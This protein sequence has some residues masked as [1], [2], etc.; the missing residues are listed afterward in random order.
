MTAALGIR[1]LALAIVVAAVAPATAAA[2]PRTLIVRADGRDV[3]AQRLS[4]CLPNHHEAARTCEEETANGPPL[5]KVRAGARARLTLKLGA[6]AGTVRAS[7]ERGARVVGRPRTLR[8]CGESLRRD[9]R[10]PRPVRTGDV[11]RL[12]LRYERGYA[13]FAVRLIVRR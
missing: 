2:D 3:S 12:F 7:V 13:T 6:E 8:A 10:L 1:S 4:S 5:P 11:V 9:V